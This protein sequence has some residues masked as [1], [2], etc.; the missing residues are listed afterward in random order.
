MARIE[1]LTNSEIKSFEMVPEFKTN[2]E[3][4]YFLSSQKISTIKR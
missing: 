2:L 4:D 3:R 1:F